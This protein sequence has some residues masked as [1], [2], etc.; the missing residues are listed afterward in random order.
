MRS[1][2]LISHRRAPNVEVERTLERIQGPEIVPRRASNRRRQ[3]RTLSF[4]ALEL[5][6][7]RRHLM[8]YA[9]VGIITTLL[10]DEHQYQHHSPPA[11]RPAGPHRPH[12][13]R[14]PWPGQL[15]TAI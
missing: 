15:H 10:G 8:F 3:T 1:L 2:Q 12:V 14:G 5:E 7:R 11:G 6:I 4:R 9:E 13:A